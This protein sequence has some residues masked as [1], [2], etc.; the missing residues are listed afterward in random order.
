MSAATSRAKT[1]LALHLLL[2][3][4]SLA[5]VASKQAAGYDFLSMG[6]VVCYGIVLVILAIYA[7]GWQ[8]IIKRLPLTTAYTNRG[9]TVVWGIFWGALI[10]GE[11]IT[12][13]KVIG[14]L[15]VCIGIAIFSHAD[16]KEELAKSHDTGA[17]GVN[18]LAGVNVPDSSNDSSSD[19]YSTRTRKKPE[20]LR[21]RDVL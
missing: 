8:Q 2:L 12:P 15:M 3:G 6:F 14:A 4:Y 10:F 1:L 5:D 18:Q 13:G 20:A 19:A 11:G 16:A 21:P 7:L 17:D 9:I